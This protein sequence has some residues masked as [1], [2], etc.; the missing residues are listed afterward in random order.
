MVDNHI[1]VVQLQCG[2]L[3]TS[4]V[5][6]HYSSACEWAA[7][8]IRAKDVLLFAGLF[9]QEGSKVESVM[10]FATLVLEQVQRDE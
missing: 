7:S 4:T 6:S 2:H 8:R 1:L 9:C 5:V 3:Q 10:Q